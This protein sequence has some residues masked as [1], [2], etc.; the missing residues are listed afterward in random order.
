MK[1]I[2]TVLF[3]SQYQDS[4]VDIFDIKSFISK[5]EAEIYLNNKSVELILD[6]IIT[7]E[8][9]IPESLQKYFDILDDKK[10]IIKEKYKNNFKVIK[11][12]YE[13]FFRGEYI[14]LKITYMIK[15]HDLKE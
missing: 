12:I 6:E 10:I 8:H 4:S 13:E 5:N 11:K 1:T 15:T 2:Y 7:N 9:K 3:Y 14:D